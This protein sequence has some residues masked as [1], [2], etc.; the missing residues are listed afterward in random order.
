MPSKEELPLTGYMGTICFR[1]SSFRPPQL[2]AQSP[3]GDVCLQ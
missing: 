2:D 1:A 3:T